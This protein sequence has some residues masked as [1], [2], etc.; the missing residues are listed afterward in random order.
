MIKTIIHKSRH[1]FARTMTTQQQ[2]N[3]QQMFQTK[4]LKVDPTSISFASSTGEPIFSDLETQTHLEEASALL[5]TTDNVVAFPTE[6]VYGLGGNSFN[7]ESIK[8]IYKA[9][10]RPA[11][12]PLISHISS[13]SQIPRF[14]SVEIPEIYKPLI[15]KFWPGP[16]TILIPNVSN[17]QIS[18]FTTAGQDTVAV[19]LPSHPI[20]RALIHLS[21]CPIAAPSANASTRPSPT[22]ASHVYHDLQGRIPVIL[23]GDN[24]QVGVESTVVDGLSSPPML[25]RPGG[26]SLEQIREFG[27]ELWKD[28]VIAK[29]LSDD[30]LEPVKTPGM[31]YK[32]YSPTAK[33]VL[34]KDEDSI[35]EYIK[36]HGLEP[37]QTKLAL[38]TCETFKGENFQG[39]VQSL[40]KSKAE[41]SSNL[42]KALRYLDEEL[43]VELIFVEQVGLSDEGLAIMNRLQKAASENI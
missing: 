40:G 43:N 31:K 4:L 33:V 18:Q 3:H 1:I 8:N 10:N 29:K 11:D 5:S 16:L 19:R 2:Q 23:D 9:K 34:V 17:S 6:T 32:H 14:F 13:P 12:N 26:V 41:I 39:I 7:D 21:D 20:A 30:S 36:E 22:L 42:F 35:A 37:D 15:A 28:V 27:G 25:L 38:L 24:A